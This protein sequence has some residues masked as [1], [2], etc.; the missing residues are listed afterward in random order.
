MG[1]GEGLLSIDPIELVQRE[2]SVIGSVQGSRA[3]LEELLTLAAEGKVRPRV[4]V[5]P[6]LMAQRALARLLEGRVRYRAV[7]RVA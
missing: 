6:L 2:A 1:L 7:V 4:E 3:E 5:F